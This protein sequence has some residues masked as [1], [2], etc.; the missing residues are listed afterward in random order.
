MG[1]LLELLDNYYLGEMDL[2][3]EM[4]WRLDENKG[5]IV[6][7]MHE[8]LNTSIGVPFPSEC[9]WSS[10]I[11][12]KSVF[13]LWELWW[14]RI[15]TIDNLIRRGLVLP[16][17]CCLCRDDAESMDHLFLH[18]PWSKPFWDNFIW[19]LGIY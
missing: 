12:T 14:N 10:Q 1:R 17:W 4:V 11:P 9:V 3:D 13:L 2:P 16:N 5:F 18:C 15:L 8:A 7:S 19:N 6:R